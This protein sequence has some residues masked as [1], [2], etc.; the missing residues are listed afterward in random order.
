[1]CISSVLCC[2]RTDVFE[3]CFRVMFF[4][5]CQPHFSIFDI[6]VASSEDQVDFRLW[7]VHL[8]RPRSLILYPSLESA[9][10]CVFLPSDY[11]RF[12]EEDNSLILQQIKREKLTLFR[13]WS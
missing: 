9:E 2:T 5:L 1:M 11:T 10:L 3:N 6:F 8:Y 7:Q 13:L 12:G 4:I